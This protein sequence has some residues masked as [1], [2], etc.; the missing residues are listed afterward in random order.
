MLQLLQS[1][2]HNFDYLRN[3]MLSPSDHKEV[4]NNP[5]H[6][7]HI[8]LLRFIRNNLGLLGRSLLLYCILS[9]S[10]R[11]LNNL[12]ILSHSDRKLNHLQ[13]R[14]QADQKS[15]QMFLFNQDRIQLQHFCKLNHYLKLLA[16]NYNRYNQHLQK[17]PHK[18]STMVIYKSR[19]SFDTNQHP[20]TIRINLLFHCQEHKGH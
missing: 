8:Q 13:I 18:S 3:N 6:Q 9:Q 20:H 7:E 19:N 5:N 12:R 4:P 15:N 1:V 16:L 2:L 11:K 14:H 17:C 10:D